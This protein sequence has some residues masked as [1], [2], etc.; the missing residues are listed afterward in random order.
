MVVAEGAGS[1]DVDGVSTHVAVE[2][3]SAHVA[4]VITVRV[5]PAV[6][7]IGMVSSGIATVPSRIAVEGG[8]VVQ[9]RT[10]GPV[11]TP[12]MPSPSAICERTNCYAGAERKCT[13]EG[14]IS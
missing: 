12:R 14:D 6:V 10:A 9:H 11:A 2:L 8:V 1:I 4:V 13:R 7:A 3:V 5:I